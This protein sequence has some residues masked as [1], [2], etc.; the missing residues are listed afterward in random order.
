[1]I[2]ECN[3]EALKVFRKYRCHP[4]EIK[5]NK[6]E[7]S[8]MAVIA[9]GWGW[10]HSH[11]SRKAR[12]SLFSVLNFTPPTHQLAQAELLYCGAESTEY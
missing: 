11:S 8:E 12:A 7:V 6:R 2:F 10:S 5:D 1:M 9:G 3:G 4:V